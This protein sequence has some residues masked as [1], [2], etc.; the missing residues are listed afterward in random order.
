MICELIKEMFEIRTYQHPY[1]NT[2]T[3]VALNWIEKVAHD[4]L[5]DQLSGC[6]GGSRDAKRSGL[7]VGAAKVRH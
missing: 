7:W 3:L 6:Y 5:L 4:D 2:K 1:D